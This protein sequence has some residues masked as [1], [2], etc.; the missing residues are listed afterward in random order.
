M[1]T[2]ILFNKDRLDKRKLNYIFNLAEY[3][4]EGY[5]VDETTKHKLSEDHPVSH[6]YSGLAAGIG[7]DSDCEF[8]YSIIAELI[9]N[10]MFND[11][12]D[13][14]I[15]SKFIKS[16]SMINDDCNLNINIGKLAK[17]LL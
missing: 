5:E 7:R 9:S 17:Y 10:S 13:P 16:L 14:N 1:F 6:M 11:S 8:E 3:M 12:E 2:D 4:T 15:R